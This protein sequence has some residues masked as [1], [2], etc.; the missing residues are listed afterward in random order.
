MRHLNV[1]SFSA[2]GYPEPEMMQLGTFFNNTYVPVLSGSFPEEA[3]NIHARCM[4]RKQSIRNK[5][6]DIV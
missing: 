3:E 2:A 1:E 4:N 6:S 5:K